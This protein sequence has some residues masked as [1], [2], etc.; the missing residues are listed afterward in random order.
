MGSRPRR[1]PS[2][3]KAVVEQPRNRATSEAAL[4][5]TS[6]RAAHEPARARAPG[7]SAG[8]AAASPRGL[9]SASSPTARRLPFPTGGPRGTIAGVPACLQGK[10]RGAPRRT[11]WPGSA[12]WV[13]GRHPGALGPPT[14]SPAARPV[15]MPWR[16]RVQIAVALPS[17]PSLPLARS[18]RPIAPRRA[19]AFLHP[20]RGTSS[21]ARDTG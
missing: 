4:R 19:G 11:R 12:P 9:L 21:P 3:K 7:Y 18:L 1:L 13:P 6:S 17:F 10:R 20:H 2:P 16:P 15:R 8:Y 14:L 5:E